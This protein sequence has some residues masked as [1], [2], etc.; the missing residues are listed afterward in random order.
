MRGKTYELVI[1]SMFIGFMAVGAN[2]SPYLTIGGVPIT[3]QLLV[4][5]LAGGMLG[6]RLGAFAMAAYMFT[7]LVGAPIFAQFKGGVG[8]L[9][10][11]TF[12]FIVSFI[13]VAYISGKIIEQSPNP[14]KRH[15]L[16]ASFAGLFLNYIIGTN[17][18]YVVLR[19]WAEAPEAFN[20]IMAWSWMLLYIPLDLLVAISSAFI[21]PRL[22]T[23]LKRYAPTNTYRSV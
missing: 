4:A 2:I 18:M 9:L 11:P 21:L 1:C 14:K 20:Y 7:G 10:S 8:S 23:A 6:S 19:F 3:L 13:F 5:L 16:F 22:H 12:G 15:F 17:Y